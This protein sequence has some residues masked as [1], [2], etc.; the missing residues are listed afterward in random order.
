[1]MPSPVNLSPSRRSAVT[2]AAERSN[3]S[4]MISRSR[5]GPTACG[6]VHR[7]HDIR[8]QHGH[9][10]VL[11]GCARRRRSVRRT[12]DR[13]ARRR[14]VPWRTTCTS[15]WHRLGHRHMPLKAEF[16][17]HLSIA[18]PVVRDSRRRRPVACAS[19]ARIRNSQMSYEDKPGFGRHGGQPVD[20]RSAPP[21][22]HGRRRAAARLRRGH[23]SPAG[24]TSRRRRRATHRPPPATGR[25]RR[26]G[27]PAAP[28]LA[29]IG[30][31]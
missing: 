16:C 29:Q 1:M 5:S 12:G 24:S 13:T 26:L 9:L 10:L 19:S 21:R 11:G 30:S 15:S 28:G 3:N 17:G 6:D 4:A 23:S 22:C 8:E 2:T 27:R 14:G 18:V 7:V 31:R 25:W 20:G